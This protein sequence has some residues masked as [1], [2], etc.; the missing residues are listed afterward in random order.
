M[1]SALMHSTKIAQVGQ[2]GYHAVCYIF[3]TGRTPPAA[4]NQA[5]SVRRCFRGVDAGPG[6][7]VIANRGN[8]E[9]ARGNGAGNRLPAAF[10]MYAIDLSGCNATAHKQCTVR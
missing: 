1:Q 5:G 7:A 4:D 9:T 2:V 8:H 6:A 10:S 3:H